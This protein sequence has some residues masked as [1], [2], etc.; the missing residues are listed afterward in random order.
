NGKKVPQVFVATGATT[1][2]AE[3]G[4]NPYT[5][6]WQPVYQGE[7]LIYAQYILKNTPNAK[8]GVI[9]QND[10]YGQDY[11]DGLTKGLGTKAAEMIVDK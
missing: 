3:F 1:F 4:A 8:I 10:D 6:G 2:S 5:Y 7:S 9:Y 11:L